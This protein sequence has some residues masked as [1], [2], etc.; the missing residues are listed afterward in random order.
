ME[1]RSITVIDQ[2][3]HREAGRAVGP[4]TRKVAACGVIANPLAGPDARDDLSELVDLSVGVGTVLTE[5]ALRALGDR[6]PSAYGKAVIVGTAGDREHG[7]A[8][9]HV[10]LGLAM[11]RGIGGGTALIPGTKKVAGPGAT[12]DLLF[13]DLE[14][15]WEYDTMD[16]MEVSVPGAPKPDEIVLVVG[17][18]AGGRPN[19]RVRGATAE[20]AAEAARALRG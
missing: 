1:I 15:A 12:I 5:R 20:Q 17:F 6:K 11:R 3:T 7:A 18:A 19:A 8:M 9:I 14:N 2:E 13:G 4:P 16:A 10:R